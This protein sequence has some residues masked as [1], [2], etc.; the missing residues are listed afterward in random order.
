M[1]ACS[2]APRE[3]NYN[4]FYSSDI[5]KKREEDNPLKQEIEK[6]QNELEL[7]KKESEWND[8]IRSHRA[9]KVKQE[10][11]KLKYIQLKASNSNNHASNL[12]KLWQWKTQNNEWITYNSIICNIIENIEIG[13]NIEFMDEDTKHNE[14][15]RE[16]KDT[17]IPI[18]KMSRDKDNN[19][20]IR[21]CR[22]IDKNKMELNHIQNES[23]LLKMKIKELNNKINKFEKDNVDTERAIIDADQI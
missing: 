12:V 10:I 7:I 11:N 8:M 1:G 4:Q 5:D 15:I 9:D 21:K 2:S 23:E 20:W 16:S 17:A 14:I 3:N 6:I 18:L 13:Q 22:R 19:P